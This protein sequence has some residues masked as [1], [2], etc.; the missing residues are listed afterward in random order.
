MRS[1]RIAVKQTA[2]VARAL[3]AFGALAGGGCDDAPGSQAIGGATSAAAAGSSSAGTIV[4][5]GTFSGDPPDCYEMVER[6]PESPEPN[7]SVSQL[8]SVEVEPVNSAGAV[9]V[10][11]DAAPGASRESTGGRLTIAAELQDALAGNPAVQLLDASERLLVEA[12]VSAP[13][14]T[15]AGYSFTVTW[16]A[17]AVLEA[18]GLT[19]VLFRAALDLNCEGGTRLVHSL[20][21]L[22]FCG[23]FADVPA[24]WAGPGDDCAVCPTFVDLRARPIVPEAPEGSPPPGR[25]ERVRAVELR[26]SG[27]R[28]IAAVSSSRV[29]RLGY[30]V[31]GEVH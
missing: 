30:A 23:G 26:R 6:L 1:V 10:T 24:T 13:T 16:P 4:I 9:R 28:S 27:G 3:L 22:H 29:P 2:V 18:Q 7:P 14:P 20:H 8:C 17:G 12:K 21:E 25:T 11:L 19:S 5:G 31:E 15:D